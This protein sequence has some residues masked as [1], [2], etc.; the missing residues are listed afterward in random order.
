MELIYLWIYNYKCIKNQGFS[1]SARYQGRAVLDSDKLTLDIEEMHSD[2]PDIQK[3]FDSIIALI[4]KNGSGKSSV[5]EAISK[6]LAG[7]IFSGPNAFIVAKKDGK[8]LVIG[9]AL[10][11]AIRL[12]N[13]DISQKAKRGLGADVHTIYYSPVFS[14]HQQ[15]IVNATRAHFTDVSNHQIYRGTNRNNRI[16]DL[17]MQL[18]YLNTS[19]LKEFNQDV[20]G[21]D[22]FL[23]IDFEEFKSLPIQ[24]KI[25]DLVETAGRNLDTRSSRSLHFLIRF[26]SALPQKLFEYLEQLE[27][28][29]AKELANSAIAQRNKLNFQHYLEDLL[30]ERFST[31]QEKHGDDKISELFF[32][33]TLQKLAFR[34][35]EV[36]SQIALLLL[37]E[38]ELNSESAI[39]SLKKLARHK[40]IQHAAEAVKNAIVNGQ[41]D[42]EEFLNIFREANLTPSFPM[43]FAPKDSNRAISI[44]NKLFFK[45]FQ[46]YGIHLG[47]KGMSSG[48]IAKLN[49][50]SRI[51]SGFLTSSTQTS[52]VLIL[53]EADSFLHPDWQRTLLKELCQYFQIVKQPPT[54]LVLMIASHSPIMISDLYPE[55]VNILT[56]ESSEQTII[57]KPLESTLGS[58]IHTLYQQEFFLK[59]TIGQIVSDRIQKVL[60][61]LANRSKSQLMEDLHFVKQLG[62]SLLR[63]G[64]FNHLQPDIDR[65]SQIEFHEQELERL[66]KSYDKN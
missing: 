1:L 32:F 40:E 5:I 59:T 25:Q 14:P 51:H 36:I 35:N 4:G 12:G 29:D 13:V 48:Q 26:F 33:I 37:L 56:R 20:V 52:I 3:P 63:E 34:N 38:T 49:L 9:N 41:S 11:A 28:G 30:Q 6:L 10:E 45:R 23:E 24:I 46:P 27:S 7:D 39:R 31:I 21:F 54:G 53:D 47:W 17:R 42:A 2:R 62:D 61:P 15:E 66:R 58:N 16:R 57:E 55:M 43:Q 44:A 18:Q 19:E 65:E 50:F 22:K 64:L 8:I 60:N